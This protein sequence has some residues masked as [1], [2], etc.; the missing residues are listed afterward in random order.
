MSTY[1]GGSRATRKC[2]VCHEIRAHEPLTVSRK[3]RKNHGRGV[4][5][6]RLFRGFS[7]GKSRSRDSLFTRL[8]KRSDS[9]FPHGRQRAASFRASKKIQKRIDKNTQKSTPDTERGIR[10][11]RDGSEVF[12]YT[13]NLCQFSV[14]KR[15]ESSFSEGF[16]EKIQKSKRDPV[17]VQS[18]VTLSE[19]L[20]LQKISRDSDRS[21]Y[22][23]EPSLPR[24]RS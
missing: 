1:A 15:R 2:V 20:G 22:P 8:L 18:T 10:N 9:L 7:F 17:A 4:A 24:R 23:A 14:R 5:L 16:S 12:F 21:A 11:F 19:Y 6:H 13:K 3:S